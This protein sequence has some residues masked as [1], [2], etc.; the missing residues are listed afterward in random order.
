ML[1]GAGLRVLE[2]LRL[3]VKDVEFSRN[4]IFVREGRGFKDRVTMLPRSIANCGFRLALFKIAIC[5]LKAA[6][7]ENHALES[8]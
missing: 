2:A 4:E 8:V 7:T 6:Q 3:R 5:D 1:Y